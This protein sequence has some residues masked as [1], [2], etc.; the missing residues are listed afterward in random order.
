M[1]KLTDDNA[2]MMARGGSFPWGNGVQ[3]FFQMKGG[4]VTAQLSVEGAEKLRRQ[5][6]EA[7]EVAKR[8]GW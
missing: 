3:L 6:D 4:Q 2:T 1:A 8:H 5:L 7:I